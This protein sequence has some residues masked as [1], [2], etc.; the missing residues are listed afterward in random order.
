VRFDLQFCTIP[1]GNSTFVAGGENMKSLCLIAAVAA[2]ALMLSSCYEMGAL[3]DGGPKMTVRQTEKFEP[4]TEESYKIGVGDF[5]EISI[6]AEDER[7]LPIA[8]D[9]FK[10]TVSVLPDG[11]VSYLYND[12]TGEVMAVGKTATDVA[13]MLQRQLVDKNKLYIG[14]RVSVLVASSSSSQ[15]YVAGEVREPGVYRLTRTTTITQA[16]VTAG[17]FT[18]FADRRHIQ[19][20]RREGDKEIRYNFNYTDWERRPR[21]TDYNDITLK[22]NDTILVSD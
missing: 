11:T 17:W 16:I 22:P 12:V 8:P 1:V 3:V 19:L 6:Q 10:R 13:K 4:Y 5:L 18:E 15:Y 14:A 7:G 20:V 21:G 2:L 9:D